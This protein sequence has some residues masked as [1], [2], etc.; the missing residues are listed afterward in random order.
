MGIDIGSYGG[1]RT[2]I[3]LRHG[4]F[5]LDKK[6]VL[7]DANHNVIAG[8]IGKTKGGD[9]VNRK[10]PRLRADAIKFTLKQ[11]IDKPNRKDKIIKKVSHA[12]S[13]RLR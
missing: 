2:I 3:R 5:L 6:Y 11:T 10:A 8:H 13:R 9:R 12:H 7:R 1:A 4:P